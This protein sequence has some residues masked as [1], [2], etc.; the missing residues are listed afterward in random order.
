MVRTDH[1]GGEGVLV[2]AVKAAEVA[3]EG[4]RV[5]VQAL[6]EQHQRGVGEPYPAVNTALHLLPTARIGHQA[7]VAHHQQAL[8]ATP[9]LSR[10]LLL[11]RCGGGCGPCGR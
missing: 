2:G 9:T 6:V 4:L 3:P 5:R 8:A 11:Q 10:C 7:P 1:M